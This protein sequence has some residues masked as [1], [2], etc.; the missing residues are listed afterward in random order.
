MSP[1]PAKISH[2]LLPF[3]TVSIDRFL[4]SGRK[5]LYY[6]LHLTIRTHFL[7]TCDKDWTL[8]SQ[9]QALGIFSQLLIFPHAS[10]PLLAVVP[11][12]PHPHIA[13]NISNSDRLPIF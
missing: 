9:S 5:K 11:A 8:D 2:S 3:N 10:F 1:K 12:L 6:E 4:S 7:V 13:I